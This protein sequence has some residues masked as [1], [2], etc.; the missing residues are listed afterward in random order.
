[1]TGSSPCHR[2][3][4]QAV[5]VKIAEF[6]AA[7]VRHVNLDLLGTPAERDTQLRRFAAEVR[8]LLDKS[9]GI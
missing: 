3:R 8:P 5:A 7:G 2:R 4:P 1:M 6:H 9:G